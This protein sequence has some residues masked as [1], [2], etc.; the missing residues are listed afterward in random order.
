MQLL[1]KS[2]NQSVL[3]LMDICVSNT[4]RQLWLRLVS[5]ERV[6]YQL[7]GT[8]ERHDCSDQKQKNLS[9]NKDKFQQNMYM[10]F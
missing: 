7:L 5:Q 10:N 4:D 1:K 9:V 2:K 8:K 3:S 6:R